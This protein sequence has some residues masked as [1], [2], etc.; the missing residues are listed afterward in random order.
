MNALRDAL[1]RAIGAHPGT[2]VPFL[3]AYGLMAR[4]RSRLRESRL[5][6]AKSLPISWISPFH[7]T[8]LMTFFLGV[9]TVSALLDR[10]EILSGSVLAAT[11]G[12]AFVGSIA[13]FDYFDLFFSPEELASELENFLFAE[14]ITEKEYLEEI[15]PR[16]GM[17]GLGGGT[18]GTFG[19]SAGGGGRT[20]SGRR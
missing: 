9:Y 16:T 15:V 14:G 5:V 11:L 8:C 13:L 3:R 17:R 12:F 20:L 19:P 18:S 7:F 4:R 6:R 2:F 10:S 1:V